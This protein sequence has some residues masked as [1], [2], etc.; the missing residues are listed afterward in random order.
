M[1]T[2]EIRQIDVKQVLR[3]KAPGIAGKIPDFLV[4]GLARLIH[5]DELN[6]ALSRYKDLQGVDF[7]QEL[8]RYFDIT[9]QLVHEENLPKGGRYIFAANHPLGGLDGICLAALI[10]SR[11]NKQVKYLVNDLLMYIPNL[12]SIFVPIN[13]H[14]AQHKSNVSLMEEAYASDNQVITFPAGLCSRKIDGK[15]QDLFWHKS[16]IRKAVQYK[17]DVVP[18]FFEGANSARFYR[19]ANL[20]KR[21]GIRMNYEMLLLPDE[22]FR[23]KHHT[24][25]IYIGKPIP[26]QTFDHQRTPLEWAAWVRNGVYNL[27]G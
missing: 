18:L 26:W 7:M 1:T 15:I 12:A 9:L 19:L 25:R 2:G 4:N 21:L 13:K 23:C 24:F 14:G 17:R 5:Q 22:M 27:K 20:R 8:T 3:Q 16:F 10:G 11:Y 6:E